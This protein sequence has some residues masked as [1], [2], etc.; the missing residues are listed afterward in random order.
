M[1]IDLW[2]CVERLATGPVISA[3]SLCPC[4]GDICD[5]GDGGDVDHEPASPKCSRSD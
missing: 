3:F 1:C 2:H 4:G 5:D